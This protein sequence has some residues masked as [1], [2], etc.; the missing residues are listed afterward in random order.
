L[1]TSAPTTNERTR[2]LSLLYLAISRAQREVIA[3]VNEDD[4]DPEVLRRAVQNGL[5]SSK[6]GS[7]V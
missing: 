3:Y 6:K 5:M 1:R 7:L 2:L 4:G